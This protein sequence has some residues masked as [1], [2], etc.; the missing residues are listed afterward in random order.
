MTTISQIILQNKAKHV[1]QTS[2]REGL[3][4]E[5]TDEAADQRTRVSTLL[6]VTITR[7]IRFLLTEPIVFLFAIYSGFLFGIICMSLP[8]QRPNRLTLADIFQSS[9]PLVFGPGGHNFN[10]GQQGLAFLGLMM[11][12]LIGA[13]LSWFQNTYYLRTVRRMG[14]GVPEARMWMARWASL[15]LPIS[16]FCM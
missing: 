16:I 3:N 8:R 9:F 6:K 14:K 11:G 7:P 1:K 15:L 10:T 5:I 12:T 2:Q 4:H 13:A